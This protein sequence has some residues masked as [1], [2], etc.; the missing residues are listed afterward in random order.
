MIMPSRRRAGIYIGPGNDI[1]HGA[2][3]MLLSTGGIMHGTGDTIQVTG[4]AMSVI[5]LLGVMVQWSS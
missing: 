3:D 1:W 5:I 4:C 2:W